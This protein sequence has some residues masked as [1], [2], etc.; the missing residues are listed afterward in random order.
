MTSNQF[1]PKRIL[2]HTLQQSKILCILRNSDFHI[3]I[4]W[5]KTQY[6]TCM[7]ILS[8]CFEKYAFAKFAGILIQLHTTCRC[9][10]SKHT[11][12]QHAQMP[13]QFFTTC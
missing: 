2:F 5:K 1:L 4:S 13:T 10:N 8:P 3:C 9:A 11:I 6:R 7:E 12:T